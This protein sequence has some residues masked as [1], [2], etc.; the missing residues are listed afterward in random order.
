LVATEI[1]AESG[2]MAKLMVRLMA[3]SPPQGA[4]PV[5]YAAVADIP[6]DSF[7]GPSH[8][9]HMRG[10]PELINRSKR[11]S[12]SELARRLWTMSEQLTGTRFSLAAPDVRV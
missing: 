7:T 4:L 1:Y 9:M 8:L 2:S 3:Q 6:G 10:A 11:A 5:L 12:D